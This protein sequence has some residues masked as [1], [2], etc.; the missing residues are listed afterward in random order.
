MSND[1]PADPMTPSD[2]GFAALHEMFLGMRR[3]GF[4]MPEAAMIIGVT[5]VQQGKDASPGAA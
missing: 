1:G 4:S 5:I 2:E 3:A